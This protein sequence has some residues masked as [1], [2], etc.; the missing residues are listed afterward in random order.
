MLGEDKLRH[1]QF[2]DLLATW[3]TSD[4]SNGMTV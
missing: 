1:Y 3:I 2:G 4:T